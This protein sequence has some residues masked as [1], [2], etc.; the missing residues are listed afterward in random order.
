MSPLTHRE[1]GDDDLPDDDPEGE[2]VTVGE[3]I[4]EFERGGWE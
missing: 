4:A 1:P 2:L 3:L